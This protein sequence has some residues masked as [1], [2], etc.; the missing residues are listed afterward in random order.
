MTDVQDKNQQSFPPWVP[1]AKDAA[2][3]FPIDRAFTEVEALFSHMTTITELG[4]HF[5]VF[6]TRRW[7]KKVQNFSYPAG[8]VDIRWIPRFKSK[9]GNSKFRQINFIDFKS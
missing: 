9:K 5:G 8:S 6:K 3:L 1:M 2:R 4:Y 7:N